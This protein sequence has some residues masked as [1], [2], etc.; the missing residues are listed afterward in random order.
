MTSINCLRGSCHCGRNQYVV[1]IPQDASSAAQ[2]IFDSD[3]RQRIS[4]AAPLSAFLRV[5]LSWY[6]SRAFAFFPDETRSAIRRVYSPPAEQHTLRHFCGFCGTP[7]SYWSERPRSEAD[8]IQLT[9]GSLLTEDLHGLDEIGLI[10][11]VFEDDSMDIVAAPTTNTGSQLIGRDTTGIPWF[12]SMISG[13]RLGSLQTTRGARESQDGR[14]RVEWEVTEWTA[15]DDEE[16]N[17][18]KRKRGE[19]ETGD[20]GNA[21]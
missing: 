18:G 3:F 5:P 6:H 4:S 15:D 10:P 12:E 19:M 17:N 7:I 11:G 9:L 1:Q 20:Q 8:Y 14:I 2:V 13:S 21:T 16:T